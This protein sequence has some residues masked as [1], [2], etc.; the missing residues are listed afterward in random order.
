MPKKLAP[1]TGVITMGG[2][3]LQ[4]A[5][6]MFTPRSSQ[7]RGGFGITDAAGS[8]SAKFRGTESGIEPGE[9]VI[10]VTKMALPD[11]SPIPEGQSA[12]DVGAQQ[13][14]PAIFSDPERSQ[15][16][17]SVSDAGGTFSFDIRATKK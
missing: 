11:G 17:V 9:Y 3:P 2:A 6:V 1:V 8:Y 4:G 5:T 14:I 13:I 7:L 12:A 15:Q 16:I 10:I